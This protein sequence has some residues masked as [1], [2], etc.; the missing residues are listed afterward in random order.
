MR[1]SDTIPL[2]HSVRRFL[3]KPI[4][5]AKA[6]QLQYVIDQCNRDF[7]THIQLVLNDPE[8]FAGQKGFENAVNYIALVAPR[9]K[10]ARKTLGYC[11][12]QLALKAQAIGLNTC[13]V[14]GTCRR[15][16][17]KAVT[18]K[19]E[20][21]FCLI[22]LGWGVDQ[23]KPRKVRPV[24]KRMAGSQPLPQWFIKGVDA[25]MLAPTSRNRQNFRFTLCPD[26]SVKLRS[27]GACRALNA[28]IL[29]YHFELGAKVPVKWRE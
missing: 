19:G 22:A 21:L 27:R 13:W 29:K 2:R 17:V 6:A 1:V 10:D 25:A 5:P 14:A 20:R 28:G 26:G 4:H 11:G 24:K 15:G 18:G 23:G 8:V 12:E 16:K 7:G 3:D 9:G